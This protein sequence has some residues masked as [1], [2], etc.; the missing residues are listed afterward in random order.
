M[1]RYID[2][3]YVSA[4][5]E[6]M[7]KEYKPT[8]EANIMLDYALAVIDTAPTVEVLAKENLIKLRDDLYRNDQ[9]TFK[10]LAK[11]NRLIYGEKE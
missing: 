3:D 1:S 5:I 11:L 4:T 6:A 10:G 2:A 9:I 8:D 7:K